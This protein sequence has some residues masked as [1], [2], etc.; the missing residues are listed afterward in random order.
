ML[1]DRMSSARCAFAPTRFLMH[2]ASATHLFRHV[3]SY[4]FFMNAFLVAIVLSRPT[5]A[6]A[7][8]DCDQGPVPG[9]YL[10]RV[11]SA[12]Q[13]ILSGGQLTTIIFEDMPAPA[14]FV[15]PVFRAEASA[16]LGLASEKLYARINGGDWNELA[17]ENESDC[18]LP[19]NC[20]NDLGNIFLPGMI[21]NSTV[22]IEVYATSAVSAKQCPDGFITFTLQYNAFMDDDCNNNRRSDFCDIADGILND[23]DGNG[24]ADD[25]QIARLPESDCNSNGIPDCCDARDGASDCNRNGVLD[26][27]EISA[28]PQLDCNRNGSLDACEIVYGYA[29]DANRNGIADACDVAGGE[30]A[31][32]N[33]NGVADIVELA[34][35]DN[36]V[37]GNYIL[38]ACESR[39]A[40]IVVDG[41]IGAP[42]LSTILNRWAT[43]DSVADLNRD[44]IVGAA[45]LSL[46]LAAW[47]PVPICG[48]G[49]HT[50]TE[51][52][53]NCPQDVGCGIGFDCYYGACMAC[54]DNSCPPKFDDCT[55]IYGS[56]PDVCYGCSDPNYGGDSV[57]CYGPAPLGIECARV[58]F[59]APRAHGFAMRI[60]EPRSGVALA[61]LG[62]VMLLAI[63]RR[64]SA[65]LCLR[66]LRRAQR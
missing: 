12:P 51:N 66:I 13:T 33:G 22:I 64:N 63:P 4:A 42:D 26:A 56:I 59:A 25:C 61:S 48:D 19:P 16:D 41:D 5:I 62:L 8:G 27:C 21:T 49:V 53:C 65:S 39:S 6:S 45:D 32:C 3:A 11:E 23:C 43:A 57:P 37:N 38:D 36:D 50:P 44:G 34:Q 14:S 18:A 10:K 30:L 17:F 7:G 2:T 24:W 54:P 35:A 28:H 20:T 9:T 47:G 40:D 52:C 55:M 60:V 29:T 31:D 15:W 1:L 46:L 58:L